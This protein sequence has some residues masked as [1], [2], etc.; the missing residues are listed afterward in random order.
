LLCLT[1]SGLPVPLITITAN[2]DIGKKFSM[3][4]AIIF[5][6]RIHPGESNSS[7]VF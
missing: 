5:S 3:R 4:E 7:F 1:L 2:K 6:S